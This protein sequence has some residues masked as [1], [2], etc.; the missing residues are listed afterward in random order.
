MSLTRKSMRARDKARSNKSNVELHLV[1][2]GT[3]TIRKLARDLA[4]CC[5]DD[6]SIDTNRFTQQTRRTTTPVTYNSRRN[7]GYSP[8]QTRPDRGKQ[9]CSVPRLLPA[10]YDPPIA[11]GPVNNASKVVTWHW[12][13]DRDRGAICDSKCGAKQH[14]TTS[15]AGRGMWWLTYRDFSLY[16]SLSII[17][18]CRR[19]YKSYNLLH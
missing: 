13:R 12:S 10:I 1:A 6:A 7:Q 19:M 17:L 8:N 18:P 16:Q 15:M 14:V 2:Q 11:V 4:G 3:P 9:R 5:L